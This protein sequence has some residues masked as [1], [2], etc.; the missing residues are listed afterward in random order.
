MNKNYVYM[1]III[2]LMIISYLPL[3]T[4]NDEESWNLTKE[5][6]IYEN[7]TAIFYLL[8]GILMLFSFV[9][10]KSEEGGYFLKTNRNYFFLLLGLLF[11]FFCGEEISW[12]Q[13]ILDIKTPEIL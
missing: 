1:I 2:L 7:F 9:R 13:R 12:G 5:D 4:L 11:L 10:S 3:F 8:S 6:G